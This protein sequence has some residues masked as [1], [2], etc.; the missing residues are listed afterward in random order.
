M[1]TAFLIIACITFALAVLLA[2][3]PLLLTRLFRPAVLASTGTLCIATG[4]GVALLATSTWAEDT[5][6]QEATLAQETGSTA[7]DESALPDGTRSVP[8][9][10]PDGTLSAPATN[11][12]ASSA[13]GSGAESVPMPKEDK[14]PSPAT[15]SLDD[16]PPRDLPVSPEAEPTVIIPPGRPAWVEAEPSLAG[17]VQTWP[18]S[19]G[20]YK[21]HAQCLRELD[22][23][24]VAAMNEYIVDYLGSDLAT[25]AIRYDAKTIRQRFVKPENIYEEELVIRDPVGTVRQVH[26]LLEFDQALRGELDAKWARFRATSRLWQGGLFAGAVLFLLGTVYSYFRLDNATRGYYTGR[27]QFLSAAAILA[28]VAIGV[29]LAR[30]I[31]WL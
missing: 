9:T 4:V 27:L 31:H 12:D 8:A 13:P 1:L 7:A 3:W 26:A 24:L 25:V 29:Y 11:E 20:P 30:W 15:D 28:L 19:A 16:Q 2:A 14:S 22:Q 23:N 17:E 6:A 10:L 18:V 21:T 5:L